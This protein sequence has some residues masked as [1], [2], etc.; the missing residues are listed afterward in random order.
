MRLPTL[1]RRAKSSGQ[2]P[3]TYV[4]SEAD[5]LPTGLFVLGD[6]GSRFPTM[7]HRM[8]AAS[9]PAAS[10]NIPRLTVEAP[11]PLPSSRRGLNRERP[12]VATLSTV[13]V[14]NASAPM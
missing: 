4:P 3:T 10:F 8:A 14:R 12:F 13:I 2:P 1:R 6:T 9:D 5:V 11:P 7:S